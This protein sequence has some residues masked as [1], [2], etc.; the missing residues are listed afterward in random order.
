MP[1][2]P[3]EDPAAPPLLPVAAAR[4]GSPGRSPPGPPARP[5]PSG[6]APGQTP[7]LRLGPVRYQGGLRVSRV[8]HLGRIECRAARP[9]GGVDLDDAVLDADL[10]QVERAR[11]RRHE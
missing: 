10:K 8:R 9:P 5:A 2:A 3:P 4:A 11:G 6:G 1:E 7:H